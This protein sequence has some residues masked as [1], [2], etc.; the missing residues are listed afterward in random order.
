MATKIK[1]TS[2]GK[3]CFIEEKAYRFAVYIYNDDP[4]TL[5]LSNV[6][7]SEE[8]RGKGFGNQILQMAENIAKKMNCNEMFLLT[9]INSFAHKWYKRHGYTD[10][11]KTKNGNMWMKKTV[12]Q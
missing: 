8:D 4:T 10:F 7:V 3:I 2:W 12:V 5:Y 1:N 9:K 11:E 6:Y